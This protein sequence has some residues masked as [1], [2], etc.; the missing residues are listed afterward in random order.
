MYRAGSC[1]ELASLHYFVGEAGDQQL[2]TQYYEWQSL[3][4]R[5]FSQPTLLSSCL[6]TANGQGNRLTDPT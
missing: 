5:A 4:L 2:H 6:V 3:L 1:V